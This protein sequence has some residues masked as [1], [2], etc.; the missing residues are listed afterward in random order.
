MPEWVVLAGVVVILVGFLCRLDT[1]AV[2]VVAGLI[3]GILGGLAGAEKLAAA[4][5]ENTLAVLGRAFVDKRFM[6]LYLLAFPMISLLERHGLR[7]KAAALMARAKGLSPG[8]LLIIY[9]FIRELAAALSM[10]LGGHA[11]FVRPLVSPM[12][13][14]AAVVKYG[15]VDA[16]GEEKLKGAAAAAENYG[17]FFGQN[18]FFA[19]SGVLLM[20]SSLDD[21]GEKVVPLAVALSSIPVA[22]ISFGLAVTFNLR[23]DRW[24]G[25][26]Q[27]EG[28][29][30]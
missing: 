9:H 15:K 23:L 8:R 28:G 24:L 6:S 21:L 16:A 13:S 7:E 25:Q 3:T 29:N 2:V 22:V 20:V 1:F 18:V 26:R 30:D 12:A 5:V 4:P 10:R 27:R 19:S 17:N 14:S 11:P